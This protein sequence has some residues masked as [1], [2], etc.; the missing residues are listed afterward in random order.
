[1]RKIPGRMIY[2]SSPDRGLELLLDLLPKI[3]EKVPEAEV[4]IFYGFSNWEKSARSRNDHGQIALIEKLKKKFGQPGVIERGR[5]GQRT[6]ARELMKAQLVAYPTWF[7]ETFCITTM[8]AMASGTPVIT[9]DV[10]AL[11]TTVGDAGVLLNVPKNQWDCG[12]TSDPLF[13]DNFV[14]ECVRMLT[15][16]AHWQEYSK[17]GLEKSA[18]FGWDGIVEDW[19]S[20]VG[21]KA[22][23]LQT[24]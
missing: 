19:L 16:E 18:K 21:Y 14:K 20:A 23:E 6:L 10:A 24:A 7:T 17:K 2:S 1:V 8:E 3:Q 22:V 13:Q 5:V 4:H 9:T 15:D 11:Q 12:I